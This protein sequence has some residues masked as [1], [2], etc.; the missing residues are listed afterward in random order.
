MSMKRIIRAIEKQIDEF[1]LKVFKIISSFLNPVLILIKNEKNQLLVFYFHALYVTEAQ[2]QLHHIDPQN[3]ITLSQFEDFIKYF[4][5]HNY[6]FVKPNDLL[7]GIPY[8]KRYVMITFDDGY[9][10]NIYA[11]EVL[12]QYK[13]PAVIFL[14]TRNVLENKSF[15]WDIIYKYRH[16][17]GQDLINI[18]N[19]QENLKKLK[20]FKIEEYIYENFGNDSFLP[21]S[22]LDR[23][24]SK[25]EVKELSASPYVIF[26]NHT[27]NHIIATNYSEEEILKEFIDSKQI[28][29]DITGENQATLAFP[30]GNFNLKT[31]ELAQK[32]D[33]KI[34]FSTIQDTNILP[35]KSSNIILLNRYMFDVS[36]IKKKGIFYRLGYD[37]ERLFYKMKNRLIQLLRIKE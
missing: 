25:T 24:L 29:I 10:N 35:E 1:G 9:Y 27:N 32:M 5:H 22:D 16:Q 33:F 3:N 28:L 13:V 8:G 15:W 34:A 11:L 36:G 2:K 18:R 4:L 19:E 37:P 7:N 17:Q 31:L 21:W 14:S 30:N 20:Y 6:E 12:K 26:G 23:P